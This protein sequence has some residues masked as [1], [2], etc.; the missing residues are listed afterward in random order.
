M[1][2][3]VIYADEYERLEKWLEEHDKTCTMQYVGA[4]GG[5]LSYEFTPTGLGVITIVRCA[6]KAEIN[7]TDFS[8][9]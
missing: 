6:C 7:L 9:W 8:E 5:R 4:I 3:F 1:K 2:N